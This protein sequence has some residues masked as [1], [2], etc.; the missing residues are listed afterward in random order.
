MTLALFLEIFGR[1]VVSYLPHTAGLSSSNFSGQACKL[2]NKAGYKIYEQYNYFNTEQLNILTC[3]AVLTFTN[4]FI[5]PSASAVEHGDH[6]S[7]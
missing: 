5:V 3:F 6:S 4:Y 1:L 7:W 2:A